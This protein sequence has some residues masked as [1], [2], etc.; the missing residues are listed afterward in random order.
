MNCGI[1]DDLTHKIYCKDFW[2]IK[3]M[4]NGKIYCTVDTK[5]PCNLPGS[6]SMKPRQIMKKI[7]KI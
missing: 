3:Y 2:R 6:E 7:I 4:K 5:Y 1:S